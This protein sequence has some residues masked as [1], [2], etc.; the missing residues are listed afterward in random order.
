M[1][2][3]DSL[4]DL[5]DLHA[6]L[7]AWASMQL[8]VPD[9]AGAEHLAQVVGRQVTTWL[10]THLVGQWGAQV[11]YVG[12]KLPCPCGQP[13]R[14]VGYRGR[15]VQSRAGEARV[16]R[17]YYHCAACQTGQLPWD[18]LQGLT[19]RVWTPEVKA[20]VAE[21]CAHLS[22]RDAATILARHCHLPLA[23]SSL[24]AIV[25]EV[26]TRLR[27]E[28]D[29]QIAAV[30]QEARPIE[31]LDPVEP[32][33]DTVQER[34]YIS[35]DAAK[36]HTGGEWHDIKVGVLYTGQ[37]S[38]PQVS[39]VSQA[40]QAPDVALPDPA[41]PPTPPTPPHDRVEASRYVAAQEPVERFGQRLYTRAVA[42][43]CDRAREVVV[44]GD[45]AA[46]IWGLAQAHFGG[47]TEILDYY[48]ACEHI[49]AL[50][51]S[52][53][54]VE[55][56]TGQR[57]AQQHCQTLK[58]KGPQPL[59]RALRRRRTRTPTAALAV[60]QALGYFTGHRR[61]MNYPAYR[62]RGLMIG[63]GPVEAACK[64]IVGQRLKQAG[65]RWSVGGAD[66]MLAVRTT[67]LNRQYARLARGARPASPHLLC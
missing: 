67:V 56:P 29:V 27:Q 43:G 26:G 48:H 35:I 51:R 6:A 14:F 41:V 16:R 1:T 38:K 54:G 44:L 12:P 42:S 2:T 53:Y 36:A 47:C 31:P 28:E 32:L 21:C 24:E 20:L 58:T 7:E 50:S 19:E 60:Q 52:L 13:A 9:I 10:F 23:E 33:P 8:T 18:Q 46:W 37:P 25:L 55:N 65:M 49:W 17:A 5:T 22:Y 59:L 11:G 40:P 30:C 39:Q 57:W 3:H 15:W 64:V 61:R 66:A 4:P 45:G 63:S 62:E 34:L